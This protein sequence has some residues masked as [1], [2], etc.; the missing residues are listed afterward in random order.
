MSMKVNENEIKVLRQLAEEYSPDEWSAY[1]FA[2]LSRITGLDL[3]VV[4]RACRS[5][6]KKGLAQYE[7]TLVDDEGRPAGA[8][9]R[10]TE[11]GAA[12]ISPCD[13]CGKRATYD[14]NVEA[15]GTFTMNDDEKTR[16]VLECEEH[17]KKSAQMP[18]Q[19]KL[20]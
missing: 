14:Y 13:I 18:Q 8:G 20:V 5:L 15:D 12:F 16:H 6:A 2:P 9:Y 19:V 7:R 1:S 11:E 17:Y 10:A 4:R 3:K